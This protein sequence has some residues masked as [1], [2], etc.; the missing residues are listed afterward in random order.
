MYVNKICFVLEAKKNQV[1]WKGED[2]DSALFNWYHLLRIEWKCNMQL[3]RDMLFMVMF[4]NLQSETL[5]HKYCLVN[6]P[7]DRV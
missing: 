7:K 5:F 6:L 2:E 3:Y 4:S 1:F